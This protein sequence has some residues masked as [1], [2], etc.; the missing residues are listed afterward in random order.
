M[1]HTY[2]IFLA[3]FLVACNGA[4]SVKV[5]VNSTNTVNASSANIPL[6]SCKE[7]NRANT[8]YTL[9]NDVSSDGT[10][11]TITAPHVVLNLNG[12]AVIYDNRAPVKIVNGDFETK[13]SDSWDISNAPNS[14]RALGT[15]VQPV[16]LYSGAYSLRF[17]LPFTGVQYVRSSKIQ[18]SANT[19]YSIS[20][21]FR[22]SGNNEIPI[23][24][25]VGGHRDPIV[26]SIEL[27]DV[28]GAAYQKGVTWRGFQYTNFI[29]TTGENA[30]ERVIRITVNHV[31]IKATGYVYV[32]DVK[33]L[34][35]PS[36]GVHVGTNYKP[37][38][39]VSI[40]NG[41]ISQG[42]GAGF[43]SDRKSVV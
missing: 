18:L 22:N 10:C 42:Q 30:E 38:K 23:N 31:P 6:T 13:L 8:T 39:H 25:Y 40:L 26:M 7:L 20:A 29:Y 16:T 15:F 21:M 9:L 17:A 11:F 5:S 4:R 12:H 36:Y 1:K 37:S 2:L 35:T 19:T 24:T 3:V 33:V 41:V 27:E 43:A 32:D 14:S 34:K 28:K